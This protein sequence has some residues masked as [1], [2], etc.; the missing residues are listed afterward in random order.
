MRI[1]L[2]VYLHWSFFVFNGMKSRKGTFAGFLLVLLSLL[3]Q[4]VYAQWGAPYSNSWIVYGKPYLKVGV[5]QKGIH[6]LPFSALPS[7]FPVNDPGKIQLW[8]RGKQVAILS[9]DNSEIL[10]YA[11]PNDGASDSLL[12][13]PM[14]SR[15]NPY[16]SMYSDESAYF[17]TIGDTAGLRA[18][19]I[20]KSADPGITP[21]S[22]HTAIYPTIYKNEYSLSTTTYLRPTFFNS[23]FEIGA[24]KTGKVSLDGKPTVYS[25][26]LV[27]PVKNTGYRPNIR[28]MVHGR[29][30]GVKNIEISVGKDAQS[31]RV[32]HSISNTGFEGS[33]YS[34][35]LADGDLDDQ[36]KGVISIK[37]SGG[38]AVDAYSLAYY[39]L[40]YSQALDLKGRNTAELGLP[41]TAQVAS[42]LTITNAPAN[43]QVLLISDPD[44]PKV[45]QG[46]LTELMVPR[47]AGKN[48]LL[49]ISNEIVTIQNTK[50]AKVDFSAKYPTN[51][52]YIIITSGNL[53]DGAKA[54]A[55]YRGSADGGG[56]R[57]LVVDVKDLYNQFNYGEP[58]PLAIRRFA[59]YMLSDSNKDKYLF[60]IG[61]SITFNERMVR[62]LPNEVPT[63]G[64]PASD[65][66]LVDGLGGTPKDIPAMPVGRLSAISNQNVLDYLQK[67]KD[68]E[69]NSTGSVGWR[70]NVLHLNGGKSVS[71][72]TQLKNLLGALVPKVS[73][74]IVGGKV[75]PFVK[76]QA[77]GEVETVNITPEVNNGVGLITYFGHGSTTVTDLDMGYITDANR[78]YSNPGMYPMMYFNGCGVGNIFSARFNPNPAAS[79][80]YPLSMDWMLTPNKGAIAIIANSF[81]SFVS[82]SSKYLNQLYTSMFTDSTSFNLSI[83]KIQVAVAK[84]ILAE[85]AGAYSVQNIHQSVLQ[86]DPAVK[87]VSVANSDY[88]VDGDQG[89]KILA[90]SPNQTIGKSKSLKVQVFVDNL[91]R[92]IEKESIPVE[93]TL[94][95]QGSKNTSKSTLK[96]FA[97]HDTLTIT[98]P[99][100]NQ[101]ERIEVRVDPAGTLKEITRSN[102][103]AELVIDWEVAQNES[104]Y[105]VGSI[106]DV[107]AP[108]LD[109]RFDGRR[110][111]N[112]E[113]I[114]PK[115]EVVLTLDDDRFISADTTHLNIFIKP[116]EDNT[117]DFKR[118]PYSKSLSLTAISDRSL[119]VKLDPEALNADGIYELLVTST[120]NAGNSS[121]TP[122]TIRFEI[123]SD[124]KTASLVVSP[125][126]AS[127][128]IRFQSHASKGSVGKTIEWKIYNVAGK[129]IHVGTETMSAEVHEWYWKPNFIA[130]GL[131][132]YKVDFVGSNESTESFSGKIAIVP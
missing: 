42:K 19:R 24:S 62:E 39:T 50:V 121:A 57:T 77:I 21:L 9:I 114:S 99:N 49:L 89:I 95:Y 46:Q 33:T 8:H 73:G 47:Q 18:E 54:Y 52:N 119:Q 122:Y 105:P 87:V 113:V 51:G 116:C 81:E 71:E 120:D 72:I 79:D 26:Q 59:D 82:P 109:V 111:K 16:W 108:L 130:P 25:F 103:N 93:L 5:T 106:K 97:Y 125:N 44:K 38:N 78:G 96:G 66:L 61:K 83:G 98:V 41:V 36:N 76:Q 85:D 115:P 12:Y 1:A 64:F 117:C 131:Y 6:K 92:F 43:G 29:S 17:L 80:R 101:L 45:I 75:T 112:G 86:G 124:E 4:N 35:D 22:Y 68:Y 48:E 100:Q 34:F 31:L 63:I 2:C 132:V 20:N 14:S 27:N 118:L 37:A 84:K 107:I 56:F 55:A 11:V 15:T 102:N 126:P 94:Y 74:G 91:G 10:F 40:S 123:K 13:R 7:D 28:L 3:G 90:E 69:H 67:V 32:V 23:Y 53:L 128:Y 129:L 127:D 88:A 58:S 110:I 104:M 30:S 60:L 70:K 65:V